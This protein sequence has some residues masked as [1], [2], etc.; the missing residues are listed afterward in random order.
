MMD[1]AWVQDLIDALQQALKD[2]KITFIIP[3]S[4][5]V[6]MEVK[7]DF[8]QMIIANRIK[9]EQIGEGAFKEFLKLK[10]EGKD[11]EALVVV[12]DALSTT[13]LVEQFKEDSIKL[14]ELARQIQE[15]RKFWLQFSSQLGVK[16]ATGLLSLALA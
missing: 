2:G 14:A 6:I 7:A 11:F 1:T 9:L 12:Y 15:T 16:L 4:E 8:I 3:P 13:E 5:Q 10:K